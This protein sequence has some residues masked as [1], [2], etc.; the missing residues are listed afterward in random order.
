MN[1]AEVI[2]EARRWIDTPFSHQGRTR[3]L[4]C[5]CRGLV[6]GVAVSLGLV[7]D[8]WWAE[9]DAMF[10]GYPEQPPPGLMKRACS[11]FMQATEDPEPGDV[12]IMAFLTDAQHMGILTPYRY[13]GLALVHSL[14][15]K[16]VREHRLA[17]SLASK[18]VQGF[19]LPG[20]V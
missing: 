3:G 18:I 5:D 15:G 20:V 11:T 4:G 17:P 12:V 19:R 13:G 9:F 7:P 10:G 8:S 2:A 6:G 16:G 14:H 1:R